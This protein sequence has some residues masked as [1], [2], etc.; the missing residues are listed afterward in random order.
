MVRRL[1]FFVVPILLV[2]GVVLGADY[3]I[4]HYQPIPDILP[5]LIH[6]ADDVMGPDLRSK[7]HTDDTGGKQMRYVRS[8]EYIGY[9]D[10]PFGRVHIAKV[11]YIRSGYKGSPT[12]PARGD[13]V[14]VFADHRL[15]VHLV[16]HLD[17]DSPLA[18]QGS[19]LL[20]L[21]GSGLL[22]DGKTVLDFAR[23]PE[24]GEVLL[25][26]KVQNVPSWSK[27]T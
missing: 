15:R 4:D 23:P 16:W 10:A 21:Q 9:C 22:E 8:A 18:V 2:T 5:R 27:G 24:S 26:G 6:A 7:G 25:D 20:E 17:E 19:R 3:S 1:P 13:R 12:P 14:L 11:F